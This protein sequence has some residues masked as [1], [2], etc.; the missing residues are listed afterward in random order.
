MISSPASAIDFAGLRVVEV[1]G[2][3]LAVEVGVGRAQRLEALLGELAR[4][5][6]GQLAAGLDR[7]FA[8]VGVDEVDGR[9]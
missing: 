9:P 4:R 6:H 2:D 5:A 1:L 7:D 3:I 8:G